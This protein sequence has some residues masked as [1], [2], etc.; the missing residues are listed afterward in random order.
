MIASNLSLLRPPKLVQYNCYTNASNAHKL[1][2]GERSQT[3]P[4]PK[5]VAHAIN[6]INN[7]ILRIAIT[8]T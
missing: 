5:R 6:N 4:L 1:R 8:T 3:M 2:S 7:V